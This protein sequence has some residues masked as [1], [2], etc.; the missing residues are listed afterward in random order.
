[1]PR[2][3]R[4]DAPGALHHIIVRGI[5]RNKIF[6]D[7]PDRNKFLDR[8][9]CIF[10][11]TKTICFAWV[12]LP[13][14]FHLLLRTG[15]SPVSAVM[16]R[17]LTGY[18]IYFNRRYHRSGHLF[19]NRYKSILCQEDGYLLELVRYIHLNPL[20]AKLVE[21]CQSLAMYPFCGHSA[22]VG[23]VDR[24]WQERD[25]ILNLFGDVLPEARRGYLQYVEDGVAKGKR[26]D[27]VGGGLVR[28]QGGW[29]AVQELRGRKAYQKGDERILGDSN[30]VE[31]VLRVSGEHLERKYHLKAQGID[32]EHLLKRVAELSGLSAPEILAG[33][34]K[35]ASVAARSVLCYWATNELGLSQAWLARKLHVSQPAISSAVRRGKDVAE[36]HHYGL[37]D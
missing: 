12:L 11:E 15:A 21:D 9:G 19:Q 35:R 14:H 20:R 37:M 23:K 33:G 36:Q 8:L 3:S 34:K 26:Q 22:I 2:K 32:F 4:I 18:A 13:N 25:Y 5:D 6:K 30:F 7:D 28:S 24:D 27:L 1:M 29:S 31:D 10:T 16:R 17:L